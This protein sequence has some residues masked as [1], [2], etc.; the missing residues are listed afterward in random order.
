MRFFVNP[1]FSLLE[2][3][4]A[5]HADFALF[6]ALVSPRLEVRSFAATTIAND[7]RRLELVIENTGWLPT[8]ITQKAV[9]KKA[10]RAV[11][12]ELELQ[13]GHGRER[14]QH[15]ELGQLM[16]LEER[17]LYRFEDRSTSDRARVE[18]VVEAKP[19]TGSRPSRAMIGWTVRTELVV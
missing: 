11:E 5:P 15:V 2:D 4:V 18:W 10:V 7:A 12:V 9:E 6:H 19:G 14:K 1:P 8:N 3:E 17:S 13:L 16:P